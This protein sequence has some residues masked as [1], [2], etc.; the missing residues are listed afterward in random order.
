MYQVKENGRIPEVTPSGAS[1]PVARPDRLPAPCLPAQAELCV[2]SRRSLH[3]GT[4]EGHGLVAESA[5]KLL[6]N[7]DAS[8]SS[9]GKTLKRP[10]LGHVTNSRRQ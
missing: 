2:K 3:Q 6:V 4:A 5:G 10:L 1:R 7:E 8:S 9:G